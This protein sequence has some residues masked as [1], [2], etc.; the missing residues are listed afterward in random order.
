MAAMLWGGSPLLYMLL[1][2]WP[3]PTLTAR[4]RTES[5]AVLLVPGSTYQFRVR[6]VDRAGNRGAWSEGPIFDLALYQESDAAVSF[7]P[8]PWPLLTSSTYS[9]STARDSSIAGR[10]VTFDF[11]GTGVAWVASFGPKYGRAEVF[12]DNVSQGVVDLY[13]AS[14]LRRRTV[15]ARLDLTDGP[16][17]LKLVILGTPNPDAIGNR[18][19]VDAFLVVEP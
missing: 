2:G 1:C 3:P 5:H 18:V 8:L 6:T 4:V 7:A 12:I 10:S 13:A 17:Q 11:D 19:E 16:H 14:T 15:F 9:G